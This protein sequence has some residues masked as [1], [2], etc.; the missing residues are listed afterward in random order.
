MVDVRI[1]EQKICHFHASGVSWS[2][3]FL[4]GFINVNYVVYGR[5]V[6][7]PREN[8]K[9]NGKSGLGDVKYER[10]RYSGTYNFRQNCQNQKLFH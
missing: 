8:D 9:T 10:I 1:W 7:N 4:V 6:P 5:R 3:G 2:L